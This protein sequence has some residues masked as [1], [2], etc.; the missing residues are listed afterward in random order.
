MP[1]ANAAHVVPV[2]SNEEEP[3]RIENAAFDL[4]PEANAKAV[5]CQGAGVLRRGVCRQS[6]LSLGLQAC[7]SPFTQAM[8]GIMQALGESVLR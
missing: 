4:T 8:R 3:A 2:E 6:T 1:S 5:A 7:R